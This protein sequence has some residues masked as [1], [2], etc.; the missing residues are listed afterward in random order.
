MPDYFDRLL[1][2]HTPTDAAA[3]RAGD[4]ARVR[5]RLP[6]PFER[7]EALRTAPPEPDEP[8]PLVPSAPG[9]AFGPAELI[10]HEREVMRDRHTVVRTEPARPD[11]E[12]ERHATAVTAVPGPLLRPPAP[13]GPAHRPVA[14]DPP[15]PPR[16]TGPPRGADDAHR[17]TPPGAVTPGVAP[18]PAAR[19][20]APARPR[21]T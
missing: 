12:P 10:R 7:V 16:R 4:M 17:A 5:P 2:R 9:P 18:A 11:G 14:A 8:A 19:T 3:D 21:G 20:V 1:A 15:R 6:G 13:A